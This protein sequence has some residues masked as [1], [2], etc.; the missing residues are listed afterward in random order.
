ME[1]VILAAGFSSRFNFEDSTFQKFLLPLKKTIILNYV[2]A[3]MYVA[4]INKINIII[5]ENVNQSQIIS[6]CYDFGREIRLNFNELELNIIENKFSERENGYSLFLGAKAVT[7]ENFIL[8]MADHIFSENVYATLLH[9]YNS[10]DIVLATDPMKIEGIYDLEDCTKVYGKNLQ[11]KL[12]GKTIP[13]YNRLDMGVFIMK[14]NIIRKI[15]S[16]IESKNSKFGV[17]DIILS[18]IDSNLNVCYLDFPNTLWVDVD[19]DFEYEK[20]K[21]N[22]EQSNR[23]KPF[24]LDIFP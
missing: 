10:E 19:N 24:N 22:V 13:K 4:G 21:K 5:D 6:C 3:G 16:L 12:I 23:I 8:S 9:N 20:L 14:T 17:S 15:S 2:I 11:I 1:S 7:S 18:A